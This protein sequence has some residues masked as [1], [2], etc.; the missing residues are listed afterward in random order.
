MTFTFREI[1][2]DDLDLLFASPDVKEAL[3]S[4]FF[5]RQHAGCMID[6][7]WRVAVI[8]ATGEMIFNIGNYSSD[9]G[10]TPRYAYL[11][12]KG[13]CTMIETAEGYELS[14]YHCS[15]ILR[16]SL[17]H[18]KEVMTQA[19]IYGGD[20][21]TGNNLKGLPEKVKRIAISRTYT[22]I[23]SKQLYFR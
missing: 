11:F 2:D 22:F 21:L 6:C 8:E 7:S 15:S 19:L 23:E 4:M 20:M 18:I 5:D 14:I 17:P 9:K 12:N 1:T 13:I 10:D 3:H 16:E